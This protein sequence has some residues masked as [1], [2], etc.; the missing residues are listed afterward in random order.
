MAENSPQRQIEPNQ[1]KVHLFAFV[2]SIVACILLSA[3]FTVS[4]VGDGQSYTA[5]LQSQ[6]NPNNAPAASLVRLPG[7]GTGRAAAIVNYRT[8]KQPGITAFRD[9]ND[10]AKVRGIGPKT[11]QNLS[12]WLKFEDLR[13]KSSK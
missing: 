7:I 3:I 2:I 6:I 1:N 11:I 10:L 13:N 8:N 12:T 4:L 5:Q 9:C